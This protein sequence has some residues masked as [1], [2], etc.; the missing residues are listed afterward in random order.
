MKTQQFGT[1][2]TMVAATA[3][4][5]AGV[6]ISNPAGAQLPPAKTANGIEYVTGGFGQEESGAFKEAQSRFA[7]SL[8]F[9]VTGTGDGSS[10]Y[11]GNVQVRIR[12]AQSGQVLDAVSTGPYFLANLSPGT[13]TVEA[14]YE[15][16]TQ[17][18]QVTIGSGKTADVKFAWKR[19]KTGPD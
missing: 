8:T 11:A 9:A 4:L 14:T 7:L 12:S 6:A 15:G 5:L 1:R 18:K 19:P 13:Y 16:D 2:I 3:V 10:P 17:T